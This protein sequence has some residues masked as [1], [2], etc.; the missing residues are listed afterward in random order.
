MA[1]T[2]KDKVNLAVAA[3]CSVA[4]V[5]GDYLISKDEEEAKVKKKVKGATSNGK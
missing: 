4:V 2:Y 5:V 3:L 1:F